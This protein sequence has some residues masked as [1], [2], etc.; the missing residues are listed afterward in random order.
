MRKYYQLAV[1]EQRVGK[2]GFVIILY[3]KPYQQA[4]EN[5]YVEDKNLAQIP[6]YKTSME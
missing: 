5:V 1:D 2:N 6:V 4:A 3:H